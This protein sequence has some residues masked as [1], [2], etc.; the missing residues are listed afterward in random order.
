MEKRMELNLLLDFYGPLLTES[1]ARIL[2]LYCEEDMSLAEIASLMGISRQ[3][4]HDAVQRAAR[5]L[6]GYERKLGMAQ[7]YRGIQADVRRARQCL[8]SARAS[9]EASPALREALDALDHIERIE[10]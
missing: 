2:S 6:E 3:G 10:E 1:R 4:V 5:Q 7:R 9:V 8:E